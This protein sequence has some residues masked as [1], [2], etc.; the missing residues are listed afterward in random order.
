MTNDQKS[1]ARLKVMLLTESDN[2]LYLLISHGYEC[3]YYL[4]PNQELATR[5]LLRRTPPPI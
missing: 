5:Y 3:V 4:A 2:K 1:E